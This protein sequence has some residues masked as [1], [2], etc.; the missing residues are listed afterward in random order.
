MEKISVANIVNFRRKKSEGTRLTLIKNLNKP[1]KQTDE[2]EPGGGDYWIHSLSTISN[3]FSTE[4]YDL[5]NEKIDF[6]SNKFDA[7]PYKRT[8]D[9]YRK[10]IEILHNFEDYDFSELKP[11][12]K[13]TFLSKSADKSILSLRGVPVQVRPHHVFTFSEKDAKKVGTVQFVSKLQ[14]YSMEELGMFADA[15]YRYLNFNYSEE[16]EVAAEYC[17]AVDVSNLVSVNYG[18]IING[19]VAAVLNET[20]D[21]IAALM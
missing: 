6:V 19:D 1:K 18:Q 15:L 7:S 20:L 9:M 5:L 16:F 17:S 4:K 12:K 21:E 14:G 8:K 10:N 11:A 2:D 13:L 3:I